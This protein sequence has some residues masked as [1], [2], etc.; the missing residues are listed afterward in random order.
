MIINEPE[1]IEE[2]KNLSKNAKGHLVH[3][4]RN[5]AQNVSNCF[6]LNKNA[7]FEDELFDFVNKLKKMGI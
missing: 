1:A 4:Y 7:E 2:I 6:E 3:L 5:F